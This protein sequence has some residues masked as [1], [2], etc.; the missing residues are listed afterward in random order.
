MIPAAAARSEPL[1]RI[2]SV[3]LP[4]VPLTTCEMGGKFVNEKALALALKVT[5]LCAAC[6]VTRATLADDGRR[7]TALACP[8]TSVDVE[9]ET[10]CAPGD[11]VNVT[12]C[13]GAGLPRL[14][15]SWT[16]RGAANT[17]P[18]APVWPFPLSTASVIG[19][20]A[21]ARMV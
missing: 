20:E 6:A 9:A 8:F 18:G 10:S 11:A 7:R 3:P 5:T 4:S 19:T 1:A 13:P 17:A 2:V 15:V 16:V 14:S 21:A 12:G